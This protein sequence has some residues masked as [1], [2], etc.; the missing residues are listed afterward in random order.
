MTWTGADGMADAAGVEVEEDIDCNAHTPAP[1]EAVTT[2]T[3]TVTAISRPRLDPR[4]RGCRGGRI[5]G[6][7]GRSGA[8]GWAT[9]GSS[10]AA[11]G[12]ATI[13]GGCSLVEGTE[14]SGAS[15]DVVGIA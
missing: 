8:G 3:K 11:E 5:V 1:T 10:P 2:T 7:G 12:A 15:T 4:R 13:A 14:M 9:T 6:L